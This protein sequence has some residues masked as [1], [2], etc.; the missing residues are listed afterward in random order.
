MT[1]ISRDCCPC[2]DD[3]EPDCMNP[4]VA[5]VTPVVGNSVTWDRLFDEPN[6]AISAQAGSVASRGYGAVSAKAGR[7]NS[8]EDADAVSAQAGRFTSYEDSGAVS[9]KA[10]LSNSYDQVADAISAQAGSTVV[11]V[12]RGSA[13]PGCIYPTSL[14]DTEDDDEDFPFGPP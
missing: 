14:S 7:S 2:L 9:A 12:K 3:F 1:L 5:A 10:G 11:K 8:Y 13:H 4:A 6:D